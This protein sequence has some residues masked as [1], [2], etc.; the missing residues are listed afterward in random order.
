[1]VFDAV[2]QKHLLADS[3]RLAMI[4]GVDVGATDP[5]F[6]RPQYGLGL[7]I[8]GDQTHGVVAGH[9]GG[10]P[11]WSTSAM[12]FSEID[13]SPLTVVALCNSDEPLAPKLVFHARAHLNQSGSSGTLR[14]A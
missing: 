4:T 13:K 3:S 10:G 6:K 12:H 11:G 14:S 7:M 2:F 5:Y 1:M 8:D 9:N